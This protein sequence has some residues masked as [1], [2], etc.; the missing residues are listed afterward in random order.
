M[1]I[2][3][4][5]EEIFYIRS[6]IFIVSLVFFISEYKSTGALLYAML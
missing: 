4:I 3:R 2:E 1:K 5:G 6:I